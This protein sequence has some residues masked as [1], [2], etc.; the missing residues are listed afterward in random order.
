MGTRTTSPVFWATRAFVPPSEQPLDRQSL[1]CSHRPGIMGHRNPPVFM[2]SIH[3]A[4]TGPSNTTQFLSEVVSAAAP[5][6]R[7]LAWA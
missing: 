5:R 6:M 3:V 7:A 4:S 2:L 1:R